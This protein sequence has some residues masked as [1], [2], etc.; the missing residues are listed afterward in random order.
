VPPVRFGKGSIDYRQRRKAM[1]S[2]RCPGQE[3]R[4]LTTSLHK[5]PQCGYMVELFSDELRALCPKCKAEILREAAP[6]CLQWCASARQCIGE[7][8][9]KALFGDD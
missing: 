3:N 8:R 1:P 9:W 7:A 2:G 6:N 5:C 4:M